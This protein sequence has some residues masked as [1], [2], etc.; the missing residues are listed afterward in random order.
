MEEVS[1]AEVQSELE[2]EE[3]EL[4]SMKNFGVGARAYVL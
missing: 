1:H 2:D 4:V 3:G